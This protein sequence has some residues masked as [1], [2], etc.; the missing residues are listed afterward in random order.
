KQQLQDKEL[1]FQIT[2]KARSLGAVDPSVVLKLVERGNIQIDEQGQVTGV[3]QAVKGLLE[4]KP[5][6]VGKPVTP[7]IGSGTN[8][9]TEQ[10]GQM[11]FKASQLQDHKFF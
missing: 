10:S 7:D 6:L 2:E 4:Q 9:G 5:Y 11:R 8:P 1:D 3:E